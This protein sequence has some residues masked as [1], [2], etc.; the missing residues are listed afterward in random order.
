MHA[1]KACGAGWPTPAGVAREARSGGEEHGRRSAG[2][3]K[4]NGKT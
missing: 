1:A 4:R 3:Q 2:E